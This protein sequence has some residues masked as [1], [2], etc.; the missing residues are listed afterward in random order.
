VQHR[1]VFQTP[2]EFIHHHLSQKAQA[3]GRYERPGGQQVV[4]QR[5]GNFLTALAS[6]LAQIEALQL[7]FNGV[8][9]MRQRQA[10][11]ALLYT[12]DGQPGAGYC[13]A[14]QRGPKLS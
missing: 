2:A 10:G 8:L 11:I 13:A 3:R 14:G 1:R 7:G 9:K 4:E 12:A 5:A 6:V